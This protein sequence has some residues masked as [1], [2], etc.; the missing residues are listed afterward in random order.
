MA[1][2]SG[3]A[4]AHGAALPAMMVPNPSTPLGAYPTQTPLPAHPQLPAD[5]YFKREKSPLSKL[6]IKGGDATSVTRIV[7]E[8]LQKTAMALNTWSSSAIQLWHHAVGLAKGARLQW[9]HGS[10]PEGFANR[11]AIHW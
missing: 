4:S 6:V 1:P 3:V 5:E 7:H 10:Q 9:T 2:V 11:V 8:W